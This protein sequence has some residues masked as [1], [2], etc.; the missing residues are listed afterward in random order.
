MKPRSGLVTH[1]GLLVFTI[2]VSACGQGA[3]SWSP[4]AQQVDNDVYALTGFDDGS[5]AS[6]FAG[7]P[8]AAVGAVQM[9]H[10]ARWDGATW[11]SVGGGVDSTVTCLE[12]VDDG[13]GPALYVGGFFNTA[14]GI[15]ASRIA[16]WDGSSWSALG[17]GVGSA[18]FDHVNAIKLFDDG[19]GPALYV[20]GGFPG[21]GTVT[22]NNVARWNGSTWSPVA[23]GFNSTVYDL[24]VH[25]DGTGPAVYA[26]G[27]FLPFIG[28]PTASYVARWNGVSA[29]WLPVGAGGPGNNVF[30][31]AVFDEGNGPALFA[32]GLNGVLARWDGTAWTSVG[33]GV[34]NG[35]V[36]AL[37]VFD[38][39]TGPALYAA[40]QF[41]MIGGV[42]ASQVAKWDGSSWTPL[43][44]GLGIATNLYPRDLAVMD[45]GV[46]RGLHVGGTFNLPA[47][48]NARMATWSCGA[49]LSLTASQA[50]PGAPIRLV[51]ANLIPGSEYFNLVSISPC[52]GTPGTGSGPYGSCL[53]FPALQFVLQQLLMPVGAEPFHVTAPSSYVG[54]GPYPVG[55][56][57]VD[58]ICVEV[59]G[60]VPGPTSPVVRITVQ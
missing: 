57:T 44:A 48:T 60:G 29:S 58:A 7:G 51:N 2:A 23:N 18:F 4:L 50:G 47:A 52:S 32:G 10:V 17:T 36:L 9:N 59:T 16:R 38:D 45:D 54:W 42:A 3:C 37:E 46:G 13:T 19:S 35:T 5:G 56:M 8:F 22:V 55:P 14:G 15:A 43:G 21:A 26:A 27:G 40:G 28:F 39:G 33:T 41:S 30:A 25:D 6:L 12:V 24:E 1:A 34:P 11:S 31:L 53:N 20:A 49:P